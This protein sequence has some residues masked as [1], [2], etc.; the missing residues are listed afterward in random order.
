[1]VRRTTYFVVLQ[2]S[3]FFSS[4]KA[5]DATSVYANKL[6][7]QSDFKAYGLTFGLGL[8]SASYEERGIEIKNT[9]QIQL[10]RSGTNKVAIC[11][12]CRPFCRVNL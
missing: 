1:M 11:R 7:Q 9:H 6:H 3:Q 10:L 12:L 8:F 4:S 5:Y 2:R